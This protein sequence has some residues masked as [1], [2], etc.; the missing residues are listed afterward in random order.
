LGAA[1]FRSAQHPGE[2]EITG[3]DAKGFESLFHAADEAT[4]GAVAAV[5]NIGKALG[6]NV[7]ARKKQ[8]STTT[9][10]HVLLHFYCD[11]LLVKG[12]LSSTKP[13]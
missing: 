8:V 7:L 12:V 4:G 11:L 5:S 9:E 3:H 13:G 2:G 1:V 6:I 10:V